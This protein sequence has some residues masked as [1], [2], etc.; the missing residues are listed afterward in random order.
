[1]PTPDSE[2]FLP[3]FVI[4]WLAI[5]GALSLMGGWY[6]LSRRFK[7][8]DA[9]DGERFY[10]RSAAI[11][12]G[13]FPVSYGNCLFVTVGSTGLA[14]SVLF[15]FRFLHPRLVIPWT[16]IERCEKVKYWF[17][18]QVAVHVAGFGRR[19]DRKSVV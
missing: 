15:P 5:C 19:L 1:M 2:W 7:S 17:T 12:R 18:N 3:A 16:D 11:G 8:N 4:F 9:I 6:E 14:L 13:I 10:F